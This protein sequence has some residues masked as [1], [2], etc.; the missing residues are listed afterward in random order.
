MRKRIKTRCAV[1][2]LSCVNGKI[3]R[4]AFVALCVI[5]MSSCCSN[6]A[7]IDEYSDSW[8][9]YCSKYHVDPSTPTE[10]QE[11]F[12]LDCYTGSV[13]EEQD[14]SGGVSNYNRGI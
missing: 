5:V 6:E 11:I 8:S 10:E 4:Y 12:Y 3:V 1:K 2:V 14:L 13:E 7:H 9:V